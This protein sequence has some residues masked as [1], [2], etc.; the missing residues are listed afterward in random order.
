MTRK[1]GKK[2]RELRK[3]QG[4]AQHELGSKIG[5]PQSTV[6]KWEAD[7]QLPTDENAERLAAFFGM[8]VPE[9]L[10]YNLGS[11]TEMPGRRINVIGE[12]AAGNWTDSPTWPEEDQYQISVILPESWGAVHIDAF[13]VRG[14]SMNKV[15]P[16]GAIVY[17][18]PFDQVPGGA[19]NG[20]YVVAVRE[21]ADGE[22][23]RSVKKYVVDGEKRTWL[24]P[25]STHPEHQTPLEF[26]KR[27]RSPTAIKIEG[28]V[29]AHLA[30]S[31]T[32]MRRG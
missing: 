3:S 32:A 7:K 31:P 28:M 12:L 24:F 8:N 19:Q 5:V 21:N 29:I 18:A 30:L 1:I 4:L 20:D 9:L 2:I 16:D 10:G 22:Y 13:E 17:V 25:E 14:P 15:Y 27:D 6:H 26:R 11:T 23:E